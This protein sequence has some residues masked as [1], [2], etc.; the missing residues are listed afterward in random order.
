MAEQAR[1]EAQLHELE[2]MRDIQVGL[3]LTHISEDDQMSVDKAPEPRPIEA[4]L[5][6]LEKFV[7]VEAFTLLPLPFFIIV[8]V[9]VVVIFLAL[10]P[11]RVSLFVVP[12]FI[13]SDSSILQ[14]SAFRQQNGD[15]VPR[16]SLEEAVELEQQ[17][18][19]ADLE[20]KRRLLER[21]QKQGLVSV[22]G[23]ALTREEQE[24][25]IRAFMCDDYLADLTT[26]DSDSDLSVAFLGTI[27]LQ[28]LT[29]KTTTMTRRM[30]TRQR[31][32]LMI[33]MTDE[34]IRTS[35]SPILRTCRT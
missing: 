1:I 25:R 14:G 20:R 30:E 33:K 15:K 19:A 10:T 21:R 29:S 2:G 5:R 34:R 22:N 23:G 8:V 28:S 16:L 18:H 9:V 27:N 24:A 12:L 4:K 3:E 6:A 17:A 11:V 35:L 26:T 31:G 7:R 13:Y 32:T